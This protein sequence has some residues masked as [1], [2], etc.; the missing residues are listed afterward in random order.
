M[1]SVIELARA[2]RWLAYHTH[3][4][5]RSAQGFP[6]LVM[7]RGDRLIFAELKSERGKLSPAQVA[8][9]DALGEVEVADPSGVTVYEWRPRDWPAIEVVLR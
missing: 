7:V 9:L 6:D 1:Q 3:D 8:W 4:S 5:R 2:C